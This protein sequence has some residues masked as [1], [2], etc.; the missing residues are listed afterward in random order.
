MA[1]ETI[2]VVDDSPTILKVVRLVLSKAGYD[3]ITASDGDE[4]LEYAKNERPDLILLDFVMPKM[5]GYQVCRELHQDA[6]LAEIPVILM[7]AKG[8][9]V[10]ERFVKVM[11]VVDYVTKPFPPDTIVELVKHTLEKR[12]QED[13]PAV[14]LP[15]V[16]RAS[17]LEVADAQMEAQQRVIDGFRKGIVAKLT[18]TLKEEHN[19]ELSS[20]SND[21]LEIWL[22]KALDDES[23]EVLIGDIRGKAPELIG[24]ADAS[25]TGILKRVPI[26]GVLSLLANQEQSGLLTVTRGH[27][28][29]DLHFRKGH[30]DMAMAAG[31][32]EEFLLGRF[33]LERELM[34]QSDL[35]L[36]MKSRSASSKLL[37]HQLV[38]LG[39]LS[40]NDL[41]EAIGSQTKALVYELL[42]WRSGFF[43]F[44]ESEEIPPIAGAAALDLNVEG[45]LLE[46]FRRSE[47]WHLIEK[48]LSDPSIIFIREDEALSTLGRGRLTR[49]ELLILEL[50]NGKNSIKDIIRLSRMGELDVFKM[51][52]RFSAVKII[53]PKVSP[54]AV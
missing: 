43:T 37:G 20:L 51:L 44:R 19:D 10:G 22:N 17:M 7:S 35:D 50:V 34:T 30:I 6:E 48:D 8:D 28:Q 41:R 2:L 13:A 46:G 38:K 36:F 27:S 29:V 47:L 53:R 15:E 12:S 23:L 24:H 32:D 3:V 11:G 26:A 5:N 16:A 31:V 4:G 18:R 42:R 33:I 1:A 45:I 52:H 40:A 25:L 39:Y 49:E 14:E 54:V 9:Q 21:R